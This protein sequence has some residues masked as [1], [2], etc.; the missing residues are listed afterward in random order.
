M[1][2]TPTAPRTRDRRI[3]AVLAILAGALGALVALRSDPTPSRPVPADVVLDEA[4]DLR[5]APVVRRLRVAGPAVLA[6]AVEGAPPGT[7]ATFGPAAP[8]EGGDAP[9]PAATTRWDAGGP[10]AVRTLRV[11]P[12]GMYVLRLEPPPAASVRGHV[13]VTRADGP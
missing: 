7:V 8:I 5:G 11:Y 12:T 13:R 10:R 3:G 2:A 4:V 9:D 1:D 6:F